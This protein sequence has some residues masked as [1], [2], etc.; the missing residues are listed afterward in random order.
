MHTSTLV[1]SGLARC[2]VRAIKFQPLA[3]WRTM[4]IDTFR[5]AVLTGIRVR[6]MLTDWAIEDT[7]LST[8][9]RSKLRR[10][11]HPRL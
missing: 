11:R 5:I 3:G 2:N 8:P 4:N 9:D 10:V 6:L 7:R 1:A